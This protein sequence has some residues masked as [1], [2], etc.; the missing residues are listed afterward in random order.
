MAGSIH[1]LYH[2]QYPG[3]TD[4]GDFLQY[5][6][7]ASRFVAGEAENLQENQRVDA[8]VMNP[9]LGFP[10]IL[11]EICGSLRSSLT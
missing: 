1:Q 3:T 6:L 11:H 7:A 9:L 2:L 5:L 10:Q 4:F 8:R